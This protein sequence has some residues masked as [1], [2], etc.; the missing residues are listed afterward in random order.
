MRALK[1]LGAGIDKRS[2]CEALDADQTELVELSTVLVSPQLLEEIE[3]RVG[4]ELAELLYT[5][6][7]LKT[8]ESRRIRAFQTCV[9][10]CPLRSQVMTMRRV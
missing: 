5:G 6:A 3:S 9:C 10:V 2:L 7:F 8:S 4:T 1:K